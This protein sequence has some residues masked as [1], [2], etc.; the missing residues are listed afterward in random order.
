MSVKMNRQLIHTIMEAATLSGLPES[1]SEELVS[2]T[3]NIVSARNEIYVSMEDSMKLFI[4]G[5]SG[6]IGSLVTK[7]LLDAG[8]QVVGLARSDESAEKLTVAGA[9]VLHGDIEDLAVLREG[10]NSAD[11]VIH[12]AFQHDQMQA[13]NMIGA[14]TVDQ[15]AIQSILG[16]L[17]GTDKPFVGTP[18]TLSLAALGRLGTEED[19]IA[20]TINPR[21]ASENMVIE[22]AKRGVRTSVVRLSPSVHG[23]HDLHGFV[24]GLIGMAR[25]KGQSA[26]ISD[27]S[28]RWPGVYEL[29]AAHLFCLAVEKAPAGTRLHGAGEQ[30]VAFK[31]IA[32]AIGEQL[33]VPV[34]S[35]TPEEAPDH[36]SYL[37]AYVA[38]DNPTSND[39]T[40]QWLDWIPTGPTLIEDIN[41]GLYFKAG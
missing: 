13:G 11:G 7:E 41:D 27:G 17:E 14:A 22:F 33:N 23:P 26:Y 1:E 5:A 19:V 9:D 37:A 39:L 35:V 10:A 6:F 20:S 40:K 31:E 15:Q 38:F 4:T 25:A 29:D 34:I 21:V 32:E 18:G 16:V 8:H 2:D 30:G 12:L 3:K 36:F 24:P 28:N